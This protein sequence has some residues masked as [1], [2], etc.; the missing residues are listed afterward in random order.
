MQS[1][2]TLQLPA[3]PGED[4]VWFLKLLT[5]EHISSFVVLHDIGVVVDMLVG[6]VVGMDVGVVVVGLYA[7]VTAM[8]NMELVAMVMDD[9]LSQNI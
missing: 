4:R 1:S 9:D 8:D 6:V 5:L 3:V 7:V 2:E